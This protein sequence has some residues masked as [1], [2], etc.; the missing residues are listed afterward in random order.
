MYIIIPVDEAFRRTVFETGVHLNELLSRYVTDVVLDKVWLLFI[1]YLSVWKLKGTIV[2]RA[3]PNA[4]ETA[5]C[6]GEWLH[7]GEN[8]MLR[9]I[10]IIIVHITMNLTISYIKSQR[11]FAYTNI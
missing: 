6:F 3:M 8:L 10:Q 11:Q 9:V 2:L 4:T 5:K 7:S 1:V